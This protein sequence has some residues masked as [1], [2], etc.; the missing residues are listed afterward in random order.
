M[1]TLLIRA[2]TK[3]ATYLVIER[4]KQG[5]VLVQQETKPL[6]SVSSYLGS[7]KAARFGGQA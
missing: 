3:S 6:A 2:D 4:T 7:L 1:K 5:T